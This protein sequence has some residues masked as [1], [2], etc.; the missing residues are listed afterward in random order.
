MKKVEVTIITANKLTASQKKVVQQALASKISLVEIKEEI[1]PEV[2]GGIKIKLGT[3]IF[4]ATVAGKLERLKSLLPEIQVTT[5]IEL[6]ANQRVKIRSA[7]E[8]KYGSVAISE[9]IDQKII[10][11][12]KIVADSKEYDATIKGKLARL[13]QQLLQT[14]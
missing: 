8:K 13:K 6:S 7:L 14:I 11:G 12:V 1:D 5:A 3:Q 2:V 9:V 10:G 4:D